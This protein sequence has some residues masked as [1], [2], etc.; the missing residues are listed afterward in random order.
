M[1]GQ[2]LRMKCCGTFL[3]ILFLQIIC[4][5]DFRAS[6][7]KIDSNDRELLFSQE[8][9]EKELS[10]GLIKIENRFKNS[11]GNEVI[12][13]S[14]NLN[15]SGQIEQ[16]QID[17]LQTSQKALIVVGADKIEFELTEANGKI[18][19]STEKRSAIPLVSTQNFGRFVRDSW[20]QLTNGQTVEFRLI[21][22]DRMETVG[23]QVAS[24]GVQLIRGKNC[25]LIEM[26]AS[27]FLIRRLVDPLNLCYIEDGKKI[28][29][30]VGRVTP[31]LK[32]GD[33]LKDLDAH[34]VYF[35]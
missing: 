24:K 32:V 8:F 29:D 22:W 7:Y 20:K 14:A 16:I 9:I 5:A 31:K 4:R 11:E 23:F 19:K 18:K 3:F 10:T 27:S 17:Q 1:E 13:E 33:Q 21:V 34:V 28:Y 2:G 6:I 12:R 26:Q 15:K 25:T 30:L 35:Y